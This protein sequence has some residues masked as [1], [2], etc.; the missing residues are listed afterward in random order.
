MNMKLIAFAIRDTKADAF[1]AQPFFCLSRGIALRNF[2]QL[3]NDQQTEPGQYPADF[4]LYEIGSFDQ[5]DGT[6]T[7]RGEGILDL[8]NGLNY[9]RKA[10]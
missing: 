3:V 6:I 7:A 8:G 1:T 2:T 10:D 9:L 5:T 4:T